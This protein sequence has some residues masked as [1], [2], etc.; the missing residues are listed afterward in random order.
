[1]NSHK[2]KLAWAW[3]LLQDEE[4]YGALDGMH[5]ERK[6]PKPYNIYMVMICDIIDKEPSN[7]EVDVEKKEWKDAMIE[8]RMM[9]GR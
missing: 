2:R 5:R 6:I 9:S 8:E 1:M 7:Y 3:E 4:I